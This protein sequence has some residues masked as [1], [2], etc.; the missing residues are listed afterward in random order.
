VELV[1]HLMQAADIQVRA[2]RMMWQ[3]G[4]S[5]G[6][7][8]VLLLG[9]QSVLRCGFAQQVHLLLLHGPEHTYLHPPLHLQR[10]SGIPVG[11]FK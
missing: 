8:R 11:L 7:V 5:T 1:V 9:L 10:A 3:A 4:Y 6:F 2:P